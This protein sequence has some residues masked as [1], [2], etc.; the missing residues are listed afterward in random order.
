MWEHRKAISPEEWWDFGVADLH[1]IG[2]SRSGDS[3][4]SSVLY[5]KA[6]VINHK[7]PPHKCTH[8]F[9]LLSFTYWYLPVPF[10]SLCIGSFFSPRS[11]SLSM[12]ASTRVHSD[13]V[14]EGRFCNYVH[15][16]WLCYHPSHHSGVHVALD[17][18][19][20]KREFAQLLC[21]EPTPH[22]QTHMHSHTYAASLPEEHNS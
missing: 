18:G 16:N 22:P 8:I 12:C 6:S 13:Q 4:T 11:S 21:Q 3:V 7:Q 19:S 2:P 1:I 9:C 17:N 15:F 10:H 20:L 14:S 5:F